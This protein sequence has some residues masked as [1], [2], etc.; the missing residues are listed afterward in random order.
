MGRILNRRLKRTFAAHFFA[1]MLFYCRPKK[2]V[3]DVSK[4]EA[5]E[6]AKEP[7]VEEP[8]KEKEEEKKPEGV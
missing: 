7:E 2:E 3:R 1:P 6:N 5:D 4:E 8:P